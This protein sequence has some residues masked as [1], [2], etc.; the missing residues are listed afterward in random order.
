MKA[1]FEQVV[2]PQGS[3]W[4]LLIRELEAIPFEWH[5]HPPV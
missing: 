5:F 4:R 2:V 1:H 3:S